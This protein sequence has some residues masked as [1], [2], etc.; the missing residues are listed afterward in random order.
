MECPQCCMVPSDPPAC[1]GLSAGI[2]LAP[3]EVS[4]L[5]SLQALD[6]SGCIN[7][8]ML[9]ACLSR[10][11]FLNQLRLADASQAPLKIHHIH[12]LYT[13]WKFDVLDLRWALQCCCAVVDKPATAERCRRGLSGMTAVR[14]VCGRLQKPGAHKACLD[15]LSRCSQPVDNG[16]GRS[17]AA[18]PSVAALSHFLDSSRCYHTAP[19]GRPHTT[20]P[21]MLTACC[22]PM[23]NA[24]P[25][26][27]KG[28]CHV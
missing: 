8:G 3:P 24:V 13:K 14:Y 25:E 12:S 10:M 20:S 17:C 7:L 23:C 5:T 11:T 18:G 4:Q 2:I 28:R 9:P 16:A 22:H 27:S 26:H 21:P 6:L 19:L 1:L 15:A